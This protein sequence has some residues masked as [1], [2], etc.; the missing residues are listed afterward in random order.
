[1]ESKRMDASKRKT[2][3]SLNTE[4]SVPIQ[5]IR[6]MLDKVG[7]ENPMLQKLSFEFVIG[8]LFPDAYDNIMKKI[9]DSYFEGYKA[10]KEEI[11]NGD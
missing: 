8:S 11:K 6:K 3:R 5:M 4:M 10:A 7:K 1:M 9:N 2:N